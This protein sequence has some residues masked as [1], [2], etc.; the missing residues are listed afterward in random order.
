METRNY[1]PKSQIFII[2]QQIPGCKFVSKNIVYDRHPSKNSKYC[3]DLLKVYN[4]QEKIL[5]ESPIKNNIKLFPM[6]LQE[7]IKDDGVYDY[8]HTNSNGSKS[9]AGYIESIMNK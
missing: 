6:Y 8:V 2:Q 9:I 5:S 4:I 3:S 7:I 1:F